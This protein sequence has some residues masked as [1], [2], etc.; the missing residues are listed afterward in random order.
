ME[1]EQSV[2]RQAWRQPSL[3][4]LSHAVPA[5]RSSEVGLVGLA[6][7]YRIVRD[8]RRLL[9]SD[10]PTLP[11][12]PTTFVRIDTR[13]R[14]SPSFRYSNKN[15]VAETPVLFPTSYW[16]QLSA[17]QSKRWLD[18]WGNTCNCPIWTFSITIYLT[19]HT[20]DVTDGALC[21]LGIVVGYK[22]ISFPGRVS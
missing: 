4:V 13:A 16:L 5:L 18:E 6:T 9:G 22:P 12:S 17:G 3:S 2:Y 1:S 20:N 15:Q 8:S 21:G 19:S 14:S 10:R 7:C 11:L